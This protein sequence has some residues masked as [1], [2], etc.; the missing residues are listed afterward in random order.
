MKY[1][2]RYDLFIREKSE[3]IPGDA[4][5]EEQAHVFDFDDTLGLTKNANGIMLY[6]DGKPA[7]GT[8]DDA[9]NWAMSLGIKETDF[10]DPKVKEVSRPNG[11]KGFA[12]Y[13]SSAGLAKIQ[14]KFD[15]EQQAV[16]GFSEPKDKKVNSE[17]QNILIDFTPSGNTD[18]STTSPIKSTIDKLKQANDQ[19]SKTIVITAR[20]AEGEG[21]DLEGKKVPATNAKDM[22]TFLAKQGAE[23]NQG[24]MGVSG[25]NKGEAIVKKFIQG[26][27]NPPDEIHFYDDLSKNTKEVSAKI[28]GKEPAE[29]FVYGPGE[30]AHG[31]ADPNKPNEKH[32]NPKEE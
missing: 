25:Q 20:Q 22:K 18:V 9:K 31:E 26:Q 6:K 23:P 5:P 17:G 27:S 1:I 28:A 11:D 13:L 14:S 29:L 4:S 2:K 8:S 3:A 16:T 24:V 7:H 32:P 19:G 15:K 10:L 21:T 30:F 12:V